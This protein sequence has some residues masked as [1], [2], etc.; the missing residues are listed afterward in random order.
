MVGY[1]WM[2]QAKNEK[3]LNCTNGLAPT[4]KMEIFQPTQINIFHLE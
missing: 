1:K 2:K 3:W 4:I